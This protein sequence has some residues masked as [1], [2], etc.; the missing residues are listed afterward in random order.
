MQIHLF[1]FDIFINSIYPE[2]V[3]IF[4]NYNSK[5]CFDLI[6]WLWLT[7]TS[8]SWL[9]IDQWL[10]CPHSGPS[11]TDKKSEIFFDSICAQRRAKIS[12][13]IEKKTSHWKARRFDEGDIAASLGR[14]VV[15]YSLTWMANQES[16]DRMCV[17]WVWAQRRTS[18]TYVSV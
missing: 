13:W 17:Q 1:R 10:S 16:Q 6:K 11:F 8:F 5:Y 4:I 2:I 9:I 15:F 7:S 18:I 12:E 14:F 3:I